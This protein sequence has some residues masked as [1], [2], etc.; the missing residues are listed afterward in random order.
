MLAC[1]AMIS[2]G[3]LKEPSI[4]KPS[5]IPGQGMLDRLLAA[6]KVLVGTCTINMAPLVGG[7]EQLS[8]MH[9]IG[10]PHVLILILLYTR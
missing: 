9:A 3:M 7:D 4:F 2:N 1:D 8:T 6:D 10:I 5:D